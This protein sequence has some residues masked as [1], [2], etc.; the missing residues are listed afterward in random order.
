MV[1]PL[2]FVTHQVL[3]PVAQGYHQ[4]AQGRLVKPVQGLLSLYVIDGNH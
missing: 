3:C 2:D 1:N 4:F